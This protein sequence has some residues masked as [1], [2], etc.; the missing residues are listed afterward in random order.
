MRTRIR[1]AGGLC[2]IVATM[3]ASYSLAALGELSYGD[4]ASSRLAM[5]GGR[6]YVF[7]QL[8]ANT[9]GVI[10]ALALALVGLG[11][12]GLRPSVRAPALALGLFWVLS[13]I[14]QLV[15]QLVWLL[16]RTVARTIDEAARVGTS[17]TITLALGGPLLMLLFLLFGV[18][19][20]VLAIWPGFAEAIGAAGP[21]RVSRPRS[22]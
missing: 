12:L 3:G 10:A 17:P 16:P 6:G 19:L 2:L 1:I 4:E 11:L 8:V 21:T 22:A 15:A 20:I 13:S 18:G 9:L 7:L 14:F 5:L